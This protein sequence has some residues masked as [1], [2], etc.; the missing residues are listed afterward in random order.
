M[1]YSILIS[2]LINLSSIPITN[3]QETVFQPKN[4]IDNYEVITISQ[5]GSLFYSVTNQIIESVKN[6]ESNVTFIGRANVGLESTRAPNE[7]I[8]VG[9]LENFLYS[10]SVKTIDSKVTNMFYSPGSTL[11]KKNS[12]ITKNNY[13]YE[14]LF[15]FPKIF[16]KSEFCYDGINSK[17]I[18]EKISKKKYVNKNQPY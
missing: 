11:L 7:D 12:P 16:Y 10:V 1:I 8:K 14:I 6:L 18:C 2:V 5:S 4:K 15:H 17:V 13:P 3:N 9:T